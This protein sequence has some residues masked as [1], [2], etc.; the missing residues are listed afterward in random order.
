MELGYLFESGRGITW[1][2]GKRIVH[3]IIPGLLGETVIGFN[4][5]GN[6]IKA[7]RCKKCKIIFFRY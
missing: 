2:K 5:L 1:D 7:Y 6:K 4:P 3:R